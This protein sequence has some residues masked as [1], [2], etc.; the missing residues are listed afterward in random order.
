MNSISNYQF[1]LLRIS[2]SF[3]F[4]LAKP[5]AGLS[6]AKFLTSRRIIR[7]SEKGTL[8]H[9]GELMAIGLRNLNAK[10]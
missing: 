3:E 2:E 9:C 8:L 10:L 5:R 6:Q 4:N 7:D 1:F